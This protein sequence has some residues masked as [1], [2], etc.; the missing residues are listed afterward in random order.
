MLGEG[1]RATIVQ[2]GLLRVGDDSTMARQVVAVQSTGLLAFAVGGLGGGNVI[3]RKVAV[4]VNRHSDFSA[5][6]ATL[7]KEI[8]NVSDTGQECCGHQ[9][10]AVDTDTAG[11]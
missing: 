9:D 5:A 4:V 1:F 7:T 10:A 8:S 2:I 3:L 6:R 11:E